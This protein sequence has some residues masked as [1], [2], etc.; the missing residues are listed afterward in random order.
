MEMGNTC[1]KI[2]QNM[3]SSYG[4]HLYKNILK[5]VEKFKEEVSF[6]KSC[7]LTSI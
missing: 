1:G 4:D 5:L 3:A 7:L 6:L 2:Y